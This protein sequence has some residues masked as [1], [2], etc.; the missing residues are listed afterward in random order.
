MLIQLII[1]QV[2]TFCILIFVLRLLFYR[3]LRASLARLKTLHEEN[4]AQEEELKKNTELLQKKKE[5]E[6]AKAKQEA[7]RIIND[8]RERAAK[9][10]SGMET[11]A[12]EQ[13]DKI[14]SKAAQQAEQSERDFALRSQEEAIQISLKIFKIVFAEDDMVLLQHQLVAGFIDELE[15]LPDE[16]FTIRE[17]PLKISCPLA[18][19][20]EEK[21]KLTRVLSEKLKNRQ[22]D[23]VE[24]IN[25]DIISGIIIQIGSFVIDGSL[26]NKLSK[27]IEYIKA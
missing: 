14:L 15:K 3:Q 5:E 7:E 20:P 18:L 2:I 8:A 13:A 22:A 26:K 17:G 9:L 21:N 1:I 27:A 19:S 25:P 16:K 4:L 24:T 23:V 6:L 11:Q 10:A 12:K